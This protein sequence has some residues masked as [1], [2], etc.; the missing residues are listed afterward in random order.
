M[1]SQERNPA[2]R[3]KKAKTGYTINKMEDAG[4]NEKETGGKEN[5]KLSKTTNKIMDVRTKFWIQET[6]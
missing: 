6:K 5:P 3:R 4:N 1:L 2:S